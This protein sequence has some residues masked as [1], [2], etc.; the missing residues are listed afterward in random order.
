MQNAARFALMKNEAQHEVFIL[1]VSD[2]VYLRQAFYS[3]KFH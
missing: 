2:D 1:K 3:V